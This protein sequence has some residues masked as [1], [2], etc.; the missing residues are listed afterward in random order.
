MNHDEMYDDEMENDIEHLFPLDISD[1]S[2]VVLCDFLAELLLAA[3]SRYLTKLRR[4]RQA[5]SPPVDPEHPWKMIQS[6]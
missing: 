3:D 5:H 6:N 4:Y 2:A 1:E